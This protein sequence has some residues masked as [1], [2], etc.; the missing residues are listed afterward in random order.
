V[1]LAVSAATTPHPAATAPAVTQRQA[2]ATYPTNAG[3]IFRWGL[4]QWH[5]GFITRLSKDWAVNRPSL[6]RNQHG[7]LTINGTSGGGDV[8]AVF[9]GH[10]RRYGRW[11]TRVRAEQYTS[12]H[13]PYKV[14]AELVPAAGRAY[15]CGAR[16][17]VLASYKLGTSRARMVIRNLPN[18]EFR[19]SK[20]RDLRPGPFHTY[21][22]EVTKTHVSW[23]VDTRVIMTE[24][25]S[26]AL[27]GETFRVRFR[28][29]AVKGREMNPGRMQMDWIRYYTLDRPNAKSI[30]APQAVRGRY[31]GAC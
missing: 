10:A 27:S 12:A 26:D 19:Y 20:S 4:S 21:A 13:T 7:M 11:E 23:F 17:I 8:N 25:R 24:R 30:E 1:T 15:H 22:V 18:A 5:D 3:K 16:S 9:T 29:V 14:V 28:L 6:V 2:T 31:A